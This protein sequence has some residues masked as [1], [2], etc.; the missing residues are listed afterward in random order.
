MYHPDNLEGVVTNA[1]ERGLPVP[2]LIAYDCLT[3]TTLGFDWSHRLVEAGYH[4]YI[5]TVFALVGWFLTQVLIAS[6]P[7]Y[8]AYGFVAI[9]YLM[10][11]DT[12]VYFYWANI[13]LSP[14][15]IVITDSYV[16]LRHG[17][18]FWTCLVMGVWSCI[19]GL[20]MTVYDTVYPDKFLTIFDLDYDHKRALAAA[21]H[22]NR[23]S[24]I[25]VSFR[26]RSQ[27]LGQQ[28]DPFVKMA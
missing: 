22:L 24:E 5:L 23:L 17:L 3:S 6:I 11:F 13:N 9:G 26:R 15:C 19:Y 18:C 8:S 1:L 4:C 7:H 20:I 12:L 27:M 16:E 25:N 14:P 2:L 10:V 21:N 28:D